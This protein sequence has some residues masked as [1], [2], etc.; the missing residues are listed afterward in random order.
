MNTGEFPQN[1][2]YIDQSEALSF[3]LQIES[4]W[5]AECFER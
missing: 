5:Y 2:A 1:F 3:R 4:F